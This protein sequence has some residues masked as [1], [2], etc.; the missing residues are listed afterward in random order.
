MTNQTRPDV[1]PFTVEII[2]NATVAI[3]D[4]MTDKLM[5]SAYNNIIYEALDF[6]VGLFDANGRTLSIGLGLPMFIGGLG[7]TVRA[8]IAALGDGLQPGDVLMTNDPYIMGSH[9]NHI[10][11]TL[12]IFHD[13]KLRAFASTMAH[14]QDIGGSLSGATTDIY[15]EGI[16]FPIL[17]VYNAGVENTDVTDILRANI[18]FPER[19][20]GDFRAQLASIH[21]GERRLGVLFTK[22]GVET[23]VDSWRQTHEH[24][25]ARARD[26]VARIPDGRYTARAYMDDDGVSADPIPLTVAVEVAGSEFTIDLSDVSDQVAGY[27]NSGETAGRSAAQVAFRCLVAPDLFPIN[28]GIFEPLTTVLPPGKIVSAERPAAMHLWMTVPMTIV[29]LVFR[30]LADAIPDQVISGH[31]ADL[32]TTTF[33]GHRPDG[34]M[35]LLTE[36][37]PGGGWGAKSDEDG[38]S[39]TICI[40][41]GNTHNTPI[42]SLEN[43]LPLL[44]R[45]Y[46][47]REDSGGAGK[48]RGGLGVLKEYEVL[49]P[50]RFNSGVERTKCAPWGLAGGLDGAPNGVELVRDSQT[51]TFPNGKLASAPL[52]VG[53]RIRLLSGGG[54]GFGDPAARAPAALADDVANGYVSAAAAA[55]LYRSAGPVRAPAQNNEMS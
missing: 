51:Q 44:I 17:K 36:G 10:V 2:R 6:T 12:P 5:R 38:M 29:D 9:L 52:A 50:L 41:D 49:T 53:D 13:G 16:A 21:T 27:Y 33:Y 23:V 47:L 32:L 42:E 30:A 8:K 34:K 19:A 26:A 22:Y 24:S 4:E 43:Q 20:M 3:T 25:V 7:D 18:R 1:D 40:N 31:H 15:S 35:F 14:W 54:G 39:A 28:E 37:L 55:S 45:E 46:A 48:H 11:L